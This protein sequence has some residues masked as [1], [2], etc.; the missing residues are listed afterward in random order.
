MIYRG[1]T[2][3]NYKRVTSINNDKRQQSQR[4]TIVLANYHH[5]QC[6]SSR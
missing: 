6:S 4:L 2:D 1:N 5:R 3:F